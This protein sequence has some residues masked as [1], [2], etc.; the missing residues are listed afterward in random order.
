MNEMVILVDPQDREIGTEEKLKAHRDGKLHRAFSVFVFNPKG[1]MLLQQRAFNKYHSGGLWTNA[2][3]SHPRPQEPVEQAAVRR[4]KEE[5]GIECALRKAF[6]F[7]YKA[8]L[9]GDLIEHEFDHVFI[10]N[11]DGKITPDANEVAEYRW[12]TVHAIKNEL[13]NSLEKY[14]VWFQLAFRRTLKFA[15]TAD[16][17]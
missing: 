16:I 15:G 1:E 12:L 13:R 3:C 2:C 4:L 7:I 8:K 17:A 9:D 5:M 14:T 11:Y 10:G 6:H